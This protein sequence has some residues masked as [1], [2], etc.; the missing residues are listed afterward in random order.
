MLEKVRQSIEKESLFTPG[1]RI[2]VAVSGGADSVCLLHLLAELRA[3]YDLEL[4]A[5]HLNHGFRGEE[6]EADARYVESLAKALG[7]ESIIRFVDVPAMMAR[8]HLSAQEAAREARHTLLKTILNERN[9]D[10]ITLGHTRD[11]RVETILGNILR[12]TGLDGLGAMPP[13]DL[14]LIRPLYE[15]T[16]AETHSYC[17]AHHLNPR[18]DLS[19]ADL[20]YCRNRLRTELLPELRTH[21]NSQIDTAILR[22]AELAVADNYF[23]EEA[24]QQAKAQCTVSDMGNLLVLESEK[25]ANLS[26]ALQRRV[27]RQAIGQVRGGLDNIDFETIEQSR[28]SAEKNSMY[29]R[30]LH[31]HQGVSIRLRQEDNRLSIERL[32]AETSAIA[33]EIELAVPGTTEIPQANLQI[34]TEILPFGEY[35]KPTSG[36]RFSLSEVQLP[37]TAR[38]R[39]NGDRLTWRMPHGTSK[40]QDILTNA[41]IPKEKRNGI[42]MIVDNSGKILCVGSI[43]RH[44]SAIDAQ[45]ILPPDEQIFEIRFHLQNESVVSEKIQGTFAGS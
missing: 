29:S 5:V 44:H 8:R 41:K 24:A 33:W 19:N 3:E 22:M 9:A 15:I 27:L 39:R 17:A 2:V 38:S 31:A 11:D 36:L 32:S 6:S 21:Y 28:M 12:G 18:Q 25:L 37:L 35:V 4:I 43:K 10:R 16:R 45:T 34:E 26:L 20:H 7:I 30:M 40:I 14:P 1:M 23:L 13:K 42:P